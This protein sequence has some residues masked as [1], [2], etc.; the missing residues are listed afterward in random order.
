[1]APKVGGVEGHISLR[2]S[3]S[4]LLVRRGS[5]DYGILEKSYF[6][7]TH[8]H[9]IEYS[10]LTPEKNTTTFAR[11]S[12]CNGTLYIMSDALNPQGPS[13]PN[14]NTS[15]NTQGNPISHSGQENSEASFK[16]HHDGGSKMDQREQGDLPVPSQHPNSATPTAMAQGV[17]DSS[18]D[19]GESVS[20]PSGSLASY[21]RH[22]LA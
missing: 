9:S 2:H 21:F 5:D 20:T 15:Y 6:F 1:M 11:V 22:S 14:I 12:H 4:C 17:R 13:Q 16:A 3:G 10:Q 18:Q 19:K 7:S 8:K